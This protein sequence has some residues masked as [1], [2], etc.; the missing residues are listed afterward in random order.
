MPGWW[1]EE[2]KTT[3]ITGVERE[4]P[5]VEVIDVDDIIDDGDDV[6]VKVEADE[7]PVK[8]DIEKCLS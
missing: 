5:G 7:E 1:F 3:E 4:T 8:D 2:T 6:I